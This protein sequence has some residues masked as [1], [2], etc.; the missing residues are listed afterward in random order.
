MFVC[1]QRW[2]KKGRRRGRGWA[3]SP[4]PPALA[5]YGPDAAINIQSPAE[6]NSSLGTGS[7]FVS[8]VCCAGRGGDVPHK[9]NRGATKS[10]RA[11]LN[12][13]SP[14][15][16]P[17]APCKWE[18]R[19]HRWEHRVGRR[20]WTSAPLLAAGSCTG[21]RAEGEMPPW[22]LCTVSAGEQG[23]RLC[24]HRVRLRDKCHHPA[25]DP[26]KPGAG[27][28]EVP[29]TP[30]SQAGLPRRQHV[31]EGKQGPALLWGSEGR[32]FHAGPNH[33]PPPRLEAG[34]Q[35]AELCASR[36]QGTCRGEP[37]S[38]DENRVPHAH[39]SSL[40]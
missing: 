23:G 11:D 10:R 34:P 36:A 26:R 37:A 15:A 35:S 33:K 4:R 40:S 30:S 21:V 32:I 18:A 38:R 6:R 25:G 19:R 17:P 2:G 8:P 24:P 20:A 22:A 27:P 39:K 16:P 12:S 5:L 7:R 13:P 31:G 3:G 29:T 14:R 28:R 9:S 1:Q